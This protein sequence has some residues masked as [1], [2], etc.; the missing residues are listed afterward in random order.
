MFV[1]CYVLR[2]KKIPQG[3]GDYYIFYGKNGIFFSCMNYTVGLF[4][5]IIVEGITYESKCWFLEKIAV[6]IRYLSL[7]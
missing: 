1:E 4:I 3:K 6:V 5:P 2:E 7:E